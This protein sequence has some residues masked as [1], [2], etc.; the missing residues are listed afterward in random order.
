MVQPCRTIIGAVQPLSDLASNC[1]ALIRSIALFQH[2]PYR[3]SGAGK[4]AVQETT[5]QAG[6]AP[7]CLLY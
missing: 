3:T 6:Y 7:S 2:H 1:S 4:Q 5:M